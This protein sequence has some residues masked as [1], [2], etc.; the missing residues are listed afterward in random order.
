MIVRDRNRASVV[1]WSIANETP[2]HDARHAFL[3]RLADEARRLDTTRLLS[4]ALLVR[5]E[6]DR[7]IVLDDPLAERL[8]VIGCN[9]YIGWYGPDPP[10]KADVVTWTNPHGK[11][12]IVSEFGADARYGLHGDAGTRWT[13]EYQERLYVHQIGMLKRIPFLRGVSP[14]ILMDFRSPRRPLPGIQDLWNRKGLLSEKGERKK[15]FYV[16]QKYYRE[17]AN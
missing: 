17:L 6:G 7:Q 14:W 16:L 13:E 8:D 1:I 3:R 11:P 2:G 5:W 12:L 15:A 4:A 10:E 9:E